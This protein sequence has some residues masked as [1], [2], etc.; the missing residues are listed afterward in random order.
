MLGLL[1]PNIEWAEAAGF[2]LAGTYRGHDAVVQ[3]VFMPL[4]TDWEGW[5]VTPDSF[6]SDGDAVVAVGTYSGK[7][8][9]TGKS[10]TARFAH[11]WKL[12][13]GKAVN[14]EQIVDSHPVQQALK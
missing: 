11:V 8:K 14:F 12:R 4:G 6:V 3:G 1:D 5:T 2:P 7:H 10:M 13:D 9:S